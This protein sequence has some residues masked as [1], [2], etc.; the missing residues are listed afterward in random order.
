MTSSASTPSTEKQGQQN[1]SVSG[2]KCGICTRRSS[3]ASLRF[4]LYS[5]SISDR[6]L[7]F[8]ESNTTAIRSGRTSRCSRISMDAYTYSAPV[9]IP[10]AVESR[11]G[12]RSFPPVARP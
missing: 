1:A 3:G 7:G 9:G 6:K 8:P 5:A 10:A 2:R 4:A 12:A 11:T